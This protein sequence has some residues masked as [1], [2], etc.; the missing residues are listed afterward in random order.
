MQIFELDKLKVQAEDI[1]KKA[2]DIFISTVIEKKDVEEKS[3]ANYVT[4]VDYK[5]QEYLI[6][7]LLNISGD[8]NIIAEE[9][10]KN[11]YNLDGITWIVDPVDGTTNLM[12]DFQH[13]AISVGLFID[14]TPRL[15]FIYNPTRNEFFSAEKGKGAFLNGNP[16]EVSKC[17]DIK[18]AL[19]GFGTTPYDRTKVNK[20]FD[21]TKNIFSACRDVRRSGSASLDIAYVACGRLDGFYELTLQ[22]W[23]FAAGLIILEEAGGKLTDCTGIKTS[24]LESTSVCVSNGKIHS[25]LLTYFESAII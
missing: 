3:F 22:P 6:Q 9:S 11:N 20:T 21:I 16:I 19:I 4:V 7:E 13:S 2:G 25:K 1:I 14:G 12:Y 23:D 5:V 8:C 24:L 18:D 17:S 10:S 15:G